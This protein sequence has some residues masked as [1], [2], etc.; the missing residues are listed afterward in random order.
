MSL[1]ALQAL[2]CGSAA[3]DINLK[4]DRYLGIGTIEQE[5]GRIRIKPVMAPEPNKKAN[6]RFSSQVPLA[7]IIWK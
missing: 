4:F 5:C 2:V 7:Q 3:A 6:P 1:C